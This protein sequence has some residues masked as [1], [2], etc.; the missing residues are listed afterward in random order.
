MVIR[1]VNIKNVHVLEALSVFKVWV[2]GQWSG[3][4]DELRPE[5][6][7]EECRAVGNFR[8]EEKPAAGSASVRP[9]LSLFWEEC[10][11]AL[12]AS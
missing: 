3:G 8:A 5:P 12:P 10:A 11:W 7:Y 2:S 1:C 9:F 4:N 6:C